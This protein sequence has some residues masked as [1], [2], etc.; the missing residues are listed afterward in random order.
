MSSRALEE[1]FALPSTREN[2]A[3][4]SDEERDMIQD[5]EL[6]PVKQKLQLVGVGA[7]VFV[8]YSA[9]FAANIAEIQFEEVDTRKRRT[10][11]YRIS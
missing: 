1:L 9:D 2:P 6:Q 7:L 8:G 11:W 3:V 4:I 10:F 5:F